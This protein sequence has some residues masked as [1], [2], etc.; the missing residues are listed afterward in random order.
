MTGSRLS[1]VLLAAVILFAA[2]GA[3][4]PAAA[5]EL[6]LKRL[7]PQGGVEA[8]PRPAPAVPPSLRQ[9]EEARQ[10]TT[11]GNQASLLGDHQ[12]ARDLFLRAA[13]LD[14]L[15]AD[16]AYRLARAHEELDEP[17]AAVREYC[18]YLALAPDA[19]EAGDV[20]QRVTELAPGEIGMPE[21]ALTAFRT[22]LE[23]ADR[24]GLREAE[25]S[26]SYVLQVAPEWADAYYNRAT[27]YAAQGQS[28]RAARD[29]RSYLEFEPQAEDRE[30]VLERVAALES[31][32]ARRAN[33][34]G[35]L[36]G[37]VVLPGFG[38]FYT[39]RPAF[40][41]LIL[42]GAGTTAY[43]A[44]QSRTVTRTETAIDPFGQPYE[45]E[46]EAT[47]YPYLAAGLA[48][49][50]AITLL[51]ALEAYLYAQRGSSAVP[52]RVV[53]ASEPTGL[54]LSSP[55]LFPTRDGIGL[56]FQLHFPAR[57]R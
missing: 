9:R 47:E 45:W 50:A 14:P 32:P 49:A 28:G 4:R 54:V 36:V 38:Q 52:T 51:G 1:G 26:F 22:A 17:G 37:G 5:Q 40:G 13:Y 12:A 29:Y 8:C 55:A 6:A 3:L 33:P 27:I 2:S 56:G 24:G 44:L 23:W 10:L 30:A 11:A 16:L 15:N 53:T 19:T 31:R 42:A 41:A 25:R 18:R 46:Y 43:L 39:R 48:G 21:P 20:Q 35:A 34:S 7:L 57:T